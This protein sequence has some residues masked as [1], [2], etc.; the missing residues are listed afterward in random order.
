MA[1]S[2]RER[3]VE[4][5]NRAFA[6]HGITGASLV[7]VTR[8]AGQ[9]NRGA[10][11]YHFGGRDELLAAV[12]EQHADFLARREG[13][14]LA[15]AQSRPDDDV[16]S[17]L[18]AVVRPCVELAESGESG[19]NYV[20]IVGEL[21]EQDPSTRAPGVEAMLARTGGYK[22][23]ALLEE[24]VATMDEELRVERFA[25]MTSFVIGSVARRLRAKSLGPRG[26]ESTVSDERFVA[27]LVNMATAMLGAP[28]VP[29]D[30]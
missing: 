30:R 21:V 20:E 27:N 7:E 18:E 10:V 12:L 8:Q 22:V 26:R 9:R 19:R 28:L 23:Y 4:A 29:P 5:A 3:L 24:R 17:V 15:L 2:T 25:L 14:L 16:Q 11:H 6:E 13:E 1:T